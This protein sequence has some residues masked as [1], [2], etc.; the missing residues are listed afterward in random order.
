LCIYKHSREKLKK[1]ENIRRKNKEKTVFFYFKETL[2]Q[3]ALGPHTKLP[4]AQQLERISG[5]AVG[6]GSGYIANC[7][8]FIF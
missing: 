8:I 3:H 2:Q 1:K 5:Q 6:L 4:A 7:T